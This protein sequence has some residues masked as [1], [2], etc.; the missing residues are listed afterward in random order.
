[1]TACART[2]FLDDARLGV[3]RGE[4]EELG[5]TVGLGFLPKR[6][7]TKEAAD[8]SNDD[9]DDADQVGGECERR[10]A[11]PRA[12]PSAKGEGT[13]ETGADRK[14]EV[15]E[16]ATAL[17]NMALGREGRPPCQYKSSKRLSRGCGRLL[18]WSRLLVGKLAWIG[19]VSEGKGCVKLGWG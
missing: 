8:R 19:L 11:R 14:G 13:I 9:D 1:L 4:G 7:E 3:G 16:E 17:E 15:D 10:V 12:G 5:A 6:F 18:T 2:A